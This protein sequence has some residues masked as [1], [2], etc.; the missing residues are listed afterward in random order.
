MFRTIPGSSVFYP[1]DPVSCERAVELAANKKGVCFIRTSRPALP[2][3]YSND[4]KFEIGKAKVGRHVDE[5]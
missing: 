2:T 5:T 1:S 4:E 3:L